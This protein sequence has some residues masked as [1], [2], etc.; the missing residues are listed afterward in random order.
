MKNPIEE[1]TVSEEDN[2]SIEELTDEEAKWYALAFGIYKWDN[3]EDL[4]RQLH[5]LEESVGIK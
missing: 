1:S 4:N 5:E 2:R 3:R